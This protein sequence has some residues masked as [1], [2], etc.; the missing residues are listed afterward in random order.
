MSIVELA[1]PEIRALVP[2]L[3]ASQVDNTI[4]L[5]ANEAP[6]KNS[7]D[8]FRR[9]L[10]RYPEIRPAQLTVLLARH[11]GCAT[12]RL[13]VTRGS[14]EAID[15][16][17][18]VFCRAGKDSIVTLTPTF[19]MYAHYAAVQGARLIECKISRERDFSIDV[20]ALLRLCDASTRLVFVCS[21]NNPTGNSVPRDDLVKLLVACDGK[22]AVVIDEAYIEFSEEASTVGLL[23]DYDNLV[24]LRTLSKALAFAGARCG[25]VMGAAPVVAMLNA[26]QAPYAMATPVVE[27]IE[28]SLNA[29]NMEAADRY[30]REIISERERLLAAVRQFAFVRRA[31]PSDA[32]FFLVEVDDAPAVLRHCEESGILLRFIGGDLEHCIRIS[33][34][35]RAENDQLLDVLWKL[36]RVAP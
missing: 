18:R 20:D 5:N 7:N 16:L 21:P 26:V 10:N 32:N 13:L 33:V 9:S 3:A 17:I 8:H 1:R 28:N 27:C 23:A 35:S 11:Y 2:Y 15:L 12:E 14:S 34:G 25:C 4:R 36:S 22:A 31:W 29:A 24:V 30:A 6:W 19:S